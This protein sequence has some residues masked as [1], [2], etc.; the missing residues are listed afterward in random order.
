MDIWSTYWYDSASQKH[1]GF[2]ALETLKPPEAI[3]GA[4][5]VSRAP[6]PSAHF[7]DG[8]GSKSMFQYVYQKS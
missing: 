4:S 8:V 2:G 6:N 5:R 1:V 7:C 3:S